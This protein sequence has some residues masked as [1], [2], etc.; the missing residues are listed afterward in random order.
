MKHTVSPQDAEPRYRKIF[1][2]AE[3]GLWEEDYSAV[4]REIQRLRGQG[5]A[6]FRI[7]SAGVPM[8]CC[9]WRA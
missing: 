7:I 5:V 3:V 1:E 9:A 4:R 8:R 2:A 6:D